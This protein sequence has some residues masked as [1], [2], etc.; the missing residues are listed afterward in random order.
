VA[1]ALAAGF[2]LSVTFVRLIFILLTFTSFIGPVLY[3]AL[4]ILIPAEKDGLSP[5]GRIVN[6]VET[7]NETDVDAR[8]PGPSS[9]SIFDRTL[10]W[11]KGLFQTPEKSEPPS[12]NR[13]PEPSA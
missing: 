5:L 3:V 7:E 1:V 6:V 4:W 2:G 11:V 9:P 10:A 8:A 12:S 13:N